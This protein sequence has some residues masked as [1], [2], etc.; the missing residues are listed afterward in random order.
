LYCEDAPCIKKCPTAINIPKFIKRIASGDVRGA[1]KTILEQNM[2][3]ASCASACPVEVLCAGDCVHKDLTNNPIEI[4]RLQRYATQVALAEEKESGRKL[5]EAAPKL[6]KKV[7]LIGAGPASLS[8]AAHLALSGVEATIFE[9]RNLPGG[10]NTTGIAAY[11]LATEQ[12]LDEVD[13]ILSHGV[14]LVTNTEI[15]KDIKASDLIK[16]Y[17]AVF[18]GM[19]LG[20]D[21]DL[22][23]PNEG[24]KG[25]WPATK[26]IEEIK[27][28][29][30]FSVPEHV[31]KAIIVGGGNTAIDAARA[32]AKLGIEDVAM[33]Y[34]GPESRM[35][36]YKH[37]MQQAYQDQV[38]F[39]GDR[40][41]K[42]IQLNDK[43]QVCGLE[44]ITTAGGKKTEVIDADW[45]VFAIGQSKLKSVVEQFK[46]VKM[47]AKGCVVVNEKTMQTT[48]EKIYAGGD[49]INGGK[50]VVN[51]AANGRDAAKDMLRQWL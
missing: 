11:K 22:G 7:A 14:E 24:A 40:Q 27:N 21:N 10:L 50:E 18:L 46:G 2:L 4:G 5:F 41:P 9:K 16:D 34:R 38:R 47:D 25:Y 31:K 12:A 43:N 3:G 33:V 44:V 15:G 19:G 6:C 37:E 49:C 42:S 48:N 39:I 23:L 35:S 13:W 45:I 17:D 29:G 1:A 36:G 30:D 51:A 28:S 26:L 20:V 32:V 8:C